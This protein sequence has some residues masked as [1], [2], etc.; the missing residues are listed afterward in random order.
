MHVRKPSAWEAG[1]RG[2]QVG[3]SLGCIMRLTQNEEEKFSHYSVMF[4]LSNILLRQKLKQDFLFIFFKLSIQK[5]NYTVGMLCFEWKLFPHRLMSLNI[6]SLVIVLFGKVMGPWRG[7]ALL[8]GITS[9]MQGL[10]D[11]AYPTANLHVSFHLLF[12]FFPPPHLWVEVLVGRPDNLD[13]TSV[14]PEGGRG[15]LNPKN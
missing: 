12:L 8:G 11:S 15:E 10:R 9:L 4:I 1:G 13:L 14:I 7:G 6:W 5:Q 3:D 2:I